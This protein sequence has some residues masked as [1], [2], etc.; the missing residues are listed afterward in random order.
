M[1][2]HSVRQWNHKLNQNAMSTVG[3]DHVHLT[4]FGV[5]SPDDPPAHINTPP[6]V[7]SSPSVLTL[8]LPV[9][10]PPDQSLILELNVTSMA[11]DL[12]HLTVSPARC[13][14][15]FLRTF[16]VEHLL[17]LEPSAISP[18][19]PLR[20]EP[21]SCQKPTVELNVTTSASEVGDSGTSP[22]SARIG[23]RLCAAAQII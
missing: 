17:D 12:K 21:P 15:L 8:L 11:S 9:A 23:V 1:E 2:P 4:A 3:L 20:S 16:D 13:A 19:P 7:L 10:S 22:G 18:A 6:P 14:S 5:S